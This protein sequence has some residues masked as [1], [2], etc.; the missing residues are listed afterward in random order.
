MIEDILGILVIV[1]VNVIDHV[2]ME[3]IY[4]I[5]IVR[6]EKNYLVNLYKN[7]LKLLKK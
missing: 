3:N 6:A 7:V 4:I 1:I 2:K 5:K